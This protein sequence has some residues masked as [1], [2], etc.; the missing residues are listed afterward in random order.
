[1]DQNLLSVDELAEKLSVPKSWIYS[2]SRQ[3]GPYAM[4]KIRCGKYIRFNW[5]DI[6]AWLERTD[7]EIDE[8]DN[9]T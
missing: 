2:R 1:M 9:S 5:I 3:S 8:N 6:L 4:P 7:G